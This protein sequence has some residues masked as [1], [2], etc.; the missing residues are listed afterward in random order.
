MG[1]LTL[2]QTPVRTSRNFHINNIKLENEPIPEKIGKFHHVEITGENEKIRVNNI[3]E[4]KICQLVYGLGEELINQSTKQANQRLRVTIEDKT[5][6][7]MQIRFRFDKEN[8]QLVD[9][10]QIEV[11]EQAKATLII[12]Y[13]AP[14]D[15]NAF[16]NGLIKLQAKNGSNIHIILV[17]MI[18]TKSNHFMTIENTLEEKAKVNY[19]I[20]DFGGKNSI[21]NYY[22][23]L[24]G[25]ASN[26]SLNTMYL[27]KENQ[28]FDFNY[29]GELQAEKSNIDIQV[30]GALKDHAK[31]HFKGTID[32]KKGCKKAT[33]NETENCMLLSNTARSLA[34]PMLLCSEEEVEGNHSCS[35]RKNRR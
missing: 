18:N 28:L 8:T 34:L 35:A 16:H 3:R 33:G 7:E 14:K 5:N 17:N 26:N 21:T 32:F 23:R 31:K 24:L 29:I 20:I 4:E 19:T 25:N 1:T 15:I 30:E 2:N 6:S 9:D 22:A 11:E 13:E 10:I 12:K 27:G